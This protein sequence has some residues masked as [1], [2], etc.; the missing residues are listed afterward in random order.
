MSGTYG[1]E[2]INR[3]MSE[4]IYD[5][6]WRRIIDT[7]GKDNRLLANG[8]SCRSQASRLSEVN[9]SHPLQALK[10]HLATS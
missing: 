8:Y 5:L 6:S 1:H 3:A 7:Q 9:L 2:T 10:R 4:K